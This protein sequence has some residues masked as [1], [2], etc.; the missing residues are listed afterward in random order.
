MDGDHVAGSPIDSSAVKGFTPGV[1]NLLQMEGVG[2]SN[3]PRQPW[4]PSWY[5]FGLDIIL[6]LAAYGVVQQYPT[7]KGLSIAGVAVLVGLTCSL[8]GG[9]LSPMDK[10]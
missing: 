8:L 9:L 7:P 3:P 2:D 10:P 1:K 6:C 5:F 4:A